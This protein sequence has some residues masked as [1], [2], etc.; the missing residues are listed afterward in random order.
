MWHVQSGYIE[1]HARQLGLSG[2]ALQVFTHNPGAQV[3]YESVGYKVS[4]FNMIKPF[5]END[6]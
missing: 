4:S 3:L 1:Q 2:M 5:V 6:A